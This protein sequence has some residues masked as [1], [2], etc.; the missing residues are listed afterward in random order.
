MEYYVGS[1]WH[2]S[3]LH[4]FLKNYLLIIQIKKIKI[5]QG[6]DELEFEDGPARVRCTQ[7]GA[8]GEAVVNRLLCPEC[9]DW[10][11]D[12]TEGEEM[13]LLSVDVET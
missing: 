12:V 9:G 13:L 8:E 11:V 1:F 5:R 4:A 10:R 6:D 7:C 2:T 3:Y